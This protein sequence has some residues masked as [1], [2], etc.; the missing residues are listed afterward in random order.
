MGQEVTYTLK[1]T[2]RQLYILKEQMTAVADPG[3]REAEEIDLLA[4]IEAAHK[5]AFN[6]EP[7]HL[8]LGLV[9][10]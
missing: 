4:R 9:E 6:R 7:Q 1:L 5:R 10:K 8:G 2:L 3:Q